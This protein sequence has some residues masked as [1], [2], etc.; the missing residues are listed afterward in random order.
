MTI[1][2][3]LER[4][5]LIGF[6]VFFVAV[7]FLFLFEIYT[8]KSFGKSP[9]VIY[10]AQKGMGANEIA[11]DL[12][13]Q[14]I[15][16]SSLFFRLFVITSNKHLKL[17]A[18]SYNLSSSMSVAKI[19]KKISS[20][21]TIRNKITIVEGWDSKD[22]AE[23]LESKKLYSQKEFLDLV[24]Q[25]FSG[26]FEFLKDKPKKLNLEGYI[27]PD[28]YEFHLEE[29]P[30]ILLK[31]ILSNF[32]KKMNT[33]LIK[34]IKAQDKSI[35]K[36]VTMASIIEKE[37]RSLE[38]KK[39]VSG[40]LWKRMANDIP[41]QVDSTVNYIT[42][43]NHSGVAIEDTKIN[44]P[45]NTYKYIGLP[46]GPISNPG[47]ESILA[48]IYPKESPFWYYLSSDKNGQTIFSK[49][50]EEHIAAQAKHFE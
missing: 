50:L 24:K 40:I 37:V 1:N 42:G 21:D 48:A 30:E 10:A 31:N 47:I 9:T 6:Y 4:K 38:D 3:E 26:D 16:K 2:P 27:F 33:D 22:I 35:F 23:Y 32:N 49:T 43:K 17:Q 19:V 46:L 44:S 12:E 11:A 28:T 14:G 13:K 8:P 15:I 45:Y 5:L 20:G 36:I 29:K 34:E 18:G 7:F 41:L 25:D 39:V